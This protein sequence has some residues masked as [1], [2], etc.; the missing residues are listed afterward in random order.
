M[1]EED[2][3]SPEPFF[4]ET[5]FKVYQHPNHRGVIRLRSS[6]PAMFPAVVAAGRGY[7]PIQQ[8]FLLAA[9]NRVQQFL[10]ALGWILRGRLCFVL[11]VVPK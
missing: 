1:P 6:L 8:S 3:L 10:S 11:V 9:E 7:R 4:Y 5:L 2:H